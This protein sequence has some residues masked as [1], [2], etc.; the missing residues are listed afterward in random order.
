V[1]KID[2]RFVA[3]DALKAL[4]DA[5]SQVPYALARAMTATAKEVRQ[6]QYDAMRRVF[7][8]P[9]PFTLR[10]LYLKAATKQ[11]QEAVT[12]L[13]D[14]F[15]T[16]A[17]YLMPQIH[18][19]NRVLKRFEQRLVMHG[20]MQPNQRAVPGAGAKLDAYGNMSRGQ[21]IQV[22]SQLRTAV[23]QGDFSNASNS[24]R[25]RAKRAA[26]TYFVSHGA[27]S[28]RFG[29][30]GKRGRGRMYEQHLPPGV[31]MRRQFAWGTAVKPVLLFVSRTNY[32][33][34]WDY[35]GIADKV[36]R[37]VLPSQLNDAI[38]EALRTARLSV[39]GGLF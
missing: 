19:G 37:D 21:I 14:G 13:K 15:G 29:Y 16:Q 24:K 7:N 34:R 1:L 25:S 22:L 4:E 2:V 36:I 12:W 35:F 31:W 26:I 30:Q 39:Q 27:G 23:V 32:S 8:S 28:R 11:R 3:K 10:S 18:G 17:H 5:Q 9:T 33:K 38:R 6:A 20:Y